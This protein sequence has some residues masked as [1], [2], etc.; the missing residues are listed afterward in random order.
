MLREI[1]LQAQPGSQGGG[2]GYGNFILIG[3]VIVIFYFF[4]IRPQQKKQKDQKRFL[5][6]IKKGDSIVTIGG[7]HGKI[8]AIENETITLEIDKGVKVTMEKSA[9]SLEASKKTNTK[10]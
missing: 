10:K 6:E 4:F 1:F 7:I 3:G 5:E 9:I 2:A 8:T